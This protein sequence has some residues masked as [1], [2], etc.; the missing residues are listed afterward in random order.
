MAGHKF[1]CQTQDSLS[2]YAVGFVGRLEMQVL[3][4]TQLMSD[5]ESRADSLSMTM[6]QL[7]IQLSESKHKQ[8]KHS[9]KRCDCC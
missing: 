1:Q 5:V 3:P 6:Q 9:L 7:L 4:L 2:C 8:L